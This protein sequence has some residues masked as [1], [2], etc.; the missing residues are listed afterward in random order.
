MHSNLD[1]TTDLADRGKP[2][3]C[4][5]PPT[6]ILES[7]VESAESGALAGEILKLDQGLT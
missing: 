3:C 5:H 6:K 7:G 1:A 4:R 2:L